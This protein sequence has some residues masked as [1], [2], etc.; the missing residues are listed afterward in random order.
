[1]KYYE[2]TAGIDLFRDMVD[3][4]YIRLQVH[5]EFPELRIAN[6]TEKAVFDR[7]WN[8]ATKASRGL[9]FD[10]D[11]G[12]VLA[13]PFPKFFNHGEVDAAP[14]QLDDEV[15][16]SDKMDGSLGI[17]Y[18]APD[19]SVRVATRGSFSSDQAIHAT[20]VLNKKYSEWTGFFKS[21]MFLTTSYNYTPL[22]E[23]IY[24][25]NRIVCDY[26]STDDLVLLGWIGKLTGE[27]FPA[28]MGEW[29]G[30]RAQSFDF[31][32]FSQVL[33]QA[34]RD[35]A[36]GFVVYSPRLNDWVKVKQ[37]DYI[38][39]HRIVTGL[40]ARRVYEALGSGQTVEE[41][42]APLPDEFHQFVRDVAEYLNTK[43]QERFMLAVQGFDYIEN[44]LR[45]LRELEQGD[46]GFRKE[47]ALMAKDSFYPS[48]LFLLL[49]DKDITGKIWR[50]FEP[51]SD[52]VPGNHEK[53]LRRNQ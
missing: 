15:W 53:F 50:M 7:E 27:Y 2:I 33:A 29:D 6:Y 18:V 1:M 5:P 25:E 52:W 14:I 20:R 28:N 49:D 35:G 45:D 48:L 24:P 4:G 21:M 11:S 8:A 23:I 13:R 39:L 16:V 51:D 9:I 17:I 44:Y 31:E 32:N 26:G 37:E 3:E 22:V 36:E 30:P 40:S 38:E 34:P 41:I 42:C 12:D 10:N 47:F 19:G 43:V 46:P